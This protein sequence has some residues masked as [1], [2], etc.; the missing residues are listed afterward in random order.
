MLVAE[1]DLDRVRLENLRVGLA[2]FGSVWTAAEER[3][4]AQARAGVTDWFA[5]GVVLTCRWLAG[6]VVEYRGRRRLPVAPITRRT[7][8]AIE[9]LIEAEYIAAVTLTGNPVS[10]LVVDRPGFLD[11]VV[12]TLAWAWRRS[13]PAPD[14]SSGPAHQ[15]H[16]LSS[17]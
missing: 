2:E 8:A 17:T 4:S 13:G 6:A 1:N 15:G 9:E 12:A 16:A 5:G 7:S 11:A 3:V 10:P 14:L